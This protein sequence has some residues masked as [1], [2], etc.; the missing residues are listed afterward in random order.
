M[1]K[2]KLY[3]RRGKGIGLLFLLASAVLATMFLMIS[4]KSAYTEIKPEVVLVANEFLPITV[5]GGKIVE[6][7]NAYK[8]IELDFGGKGEKKDLFP[9]VLD[10]RNEVSSVPTE[11]QGL[12][13]TTDMVYAVTA[14]QIRRLNLQT[15]QDGVLTKENFAEIMDGVVGYVS[16]FAAMIL[17]AMY[18]LTLLL[19]TW[20]AALLGRVALK[21]MKKP[22]MLN[23]SGLMRLSAMTAAVTELGSYFVGMGFG[24]TGWHTFIIIVA[25]VLLVLYKMQP[26][27]SKNDSILPGE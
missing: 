17:V 3:I 9:V 21:V 18:F 2:I 7:A 1:E 11:P 23:M 14:D 5:K 8:R 24:L 10:T 16:S 12:F 19:K 6:P 26:E 15:Q 22:E 20:L 13:I 27:D 25:V 4:L